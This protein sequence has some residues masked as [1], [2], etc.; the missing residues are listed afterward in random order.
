MHLGKDLVEGLLGVGEVGA[1]PASAIP[2]LDLQMLS[3]RAFAACD[4]A[5][6]KQSISPVNR[7]VTQES[8]G[9]PC[10]LHLHCGGTTAS[11]RHAARGRWFQLIPRPSPKLRTNH[12]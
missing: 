4:M 8:L 12:H 6:R 1:T 11:A 2:K 7:F 5:T 9:A 3:S 10:R